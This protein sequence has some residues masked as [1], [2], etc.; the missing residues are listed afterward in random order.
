MLRG[1]KSYMNMK[2][3]KYIGLG[4]L[5]L[6]CSC[7]GRDRQVEEALSLSG[8]NRNELEAVLKH[9]E[10]D[11]R[12]LEAA[13]FLIGNM[14]G[15]YGANPIVEQDCSAFYEA[16]DSLGQK[17]GYRVGTEWGKQVDSLWKDFSN[18]HRVRQELNY[19]I[20]RMKAEDLIREID[21]AF[22]AWVENVHS[23]N[24]SFEDFCEYILPYRRQ[25]GL[26]IDNARRE[27]NKRH[28]GKYFVK[29]GKDWQQEID[30]LLYEYKYLTHSG[31]WGTKIPI[32]NA[33]TLEKMR[34]GL[35][36]QR[37]WYNSLLL[38]SL[39]IPVAIDFVPAWGNRNNSHTWNV[40]L[41]N[42]ESHAFEA[43][44]DN[45]RWKYKRIYNNRNDDELWGRFRLPKVYRYTYSNHIEG[46]L[47]DVEVDKAD[48]PELFRSVKKVDVS[49]EYF[50]TADVTVEL[51]GEAPQG[52]KY[53]YLAVF[54]YQDWHP[55]QWG[56]VENGRAVFREMGKDMV[57]LPVYYKRGGLLP[58]AEPF[59]LRNDG[60]MEKLSGN[61][62][63]EEVAV[64][65][66]TG[67]P[68][69]DQNKEYLG[70]MKGSRIV[71]LLD[72]KSEE[73][74]CRWTDSLAL[75]SVVRKV[76]ARLPYRFVRLLLPSD[77][78]A[79]GELSFYTEEGRI[80]N[81]R[82]ITPMRATGRNEVPGMITDGLGAT[83][84]RGRVAERLVDIDLGK[85]YMV[86]HIGMTSYLKTQLFCPDEF[87]LRY[88][89]NGWKTVERKQADH[90]GYLVFER[91]PRGALLMLKNCRWKGKTAERI[92]TYEKGD[93]K[94]E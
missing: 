72:G 21:L 66:V 94:W 82:I 47:A 58:A 79:L 34:H 25:N 67:A 10:G 51:T 70:C 20:T 90:K 32:W 56:K 60:T 26:L 29:E 27:F 35:C 85:E 62:E 30:S 83:G 28:Q 22:R 84:Y 55:V 1:E 41:I 42:G 59:R 89:D 14:P 13:R 86:S 36:A 15:S 50:E 68:A 4:L 7:G 77:S 12:K 16:Y 74:L 40:V 75:Q 18:R 8:N 57:Y 81:V 5:P 31:F 54:G 73:E 91:V 46:P 52:V 61:E 71:G 37:C 92:F 49:S 33:A 3:M 19:D 38:S 23:R 44:W 53:A 39:G 87:E 65:M 17:Y 78:I 9:Y 11:G 48:I 88:W 43:F 45:D 6:V 63:T 2:I 76:S 24:C 64:R 69:Y 80:G 93:V